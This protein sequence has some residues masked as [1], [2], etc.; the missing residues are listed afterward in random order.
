M[1]GHHSSW[2]PEPIDP[3]G[4]KDKTMNR[5]LTLPRFGLLAAALAILPI[6]AFAQTGTMDGSTAA[7]VTTPAAQTDA[8]TPAPVQKPLVAHRMKHAAVSATGAVKTAAPAA[9]T[10]AVQPKTIDQ[11]K[12]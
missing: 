5:I 12:S 7:P 6:S 1:I 2:Q 11:G 10:S 8:K 9:K 3:S 4:G